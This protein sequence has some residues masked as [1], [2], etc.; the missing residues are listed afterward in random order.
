MSNSPNKANLN[1][2]TF[3]KMADQWWD[4]K[5]PM[6]ALHSINET[7]VKF[8]QSTHKINN[9]KII[10]IGCG[11]GILSEALCALGSKVT[12]IDI[13]EELIEVAKKHSMENKLD[14]KYILSS[15]ENLE[16]THNARYDV[17]TC[18]EMLEH[19]SDPSMIISHCARLVKKGGYLYLSTLNRTLKARIFGIIVAENFLN[20]VPKHTHSYE[21]FIKPSEIDQMLSQSGFRISRIN[22]ISYNPFTNFSK[23]NSDISIN[24]IV[25][26]IKI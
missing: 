13:S 22:G 7:R 14:V 6:K 2:D 24:Y 19:V 15:I 12:G 20:V 5:G 4:V 3:N 23:L 18:M 10:D 11:G 9:I 1:N 26:A 16:E 25:E 17:I 8:I 21:A